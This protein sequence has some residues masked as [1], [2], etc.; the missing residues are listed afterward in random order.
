MIFY[1]FIQFDQNNKLPIYTLFNFNFNKYKLDFNITSDSKYTIFTH[2]WSNNDFD[3][4]KPYIVRSDFTSYFLPIEQKM[5]DYVNNYG[6]LHNNYFSKT[7]NI[8]YI[9]YDTLLIQQFDLNYYNN[10]QIRKLQ[11]F[12]Y[13]T[14]EHLY[15]KYNFDFDKY[16]ND[17][18]I[19]GSN[20]LL[21]TDFILRN[22]QLTNNSDTNTY[23][24]YEPFKKYFILSNKNLLKNYL[25]DYSVTSV[26]NYS[27]HNLNNIDF[28]KSNLNID[29]YLI[30]DQFKQL[31]I[32]FINKNNDYTTIAKQSS[33]SFI[34]K[35]SYSSGFLYD[36][37]D[38]NLYIVSTYHGVVDDID[39]FY[40]W[41]SFQYNDPNNYNNISITAQFRIIGIDIRSDIVIAIYDPNLEFNKEFNVDLSPYKPL[42]INRKHV[43]SDGD[44]VV[45]IGNSY[46]TAI[47]HVVLGKVID[48]IYAGS[49]KE[50]IRNYSYLIQT[51]LSVGMSGSPI[52]Y[53]NNNNELSLIGMI[54]T[55]LTQSPQLCIGV[56]NYILYNILNTLIE[57]YHQNLIIYKDNI[58]LLNN[59]IKDGYNY[60]F[61]GASGNYYNQLH[62]KNKNIYPSL[63][64]LNYAGGYLINNFYLA[65]NIETKQ[66]VISPKDLNK[67]NVIPIYPPLF[68]SKMYSRYLSSNNPI[69]L[70]NY[71]YYDIKTDNYQ[72]YNI[73]RLSTQKPLSTLMQG[74]QPII[75][76]N[77]DSKYKNK[78]LYEYPTVN[79]EYYWYN[80]QTWELENEFI[81]GNIFVEYNDKNGNL[82][83]QNRYEFPYI[84]INYVPYIN[85][86][87][88]LTNNEYNMLL[89][90]KCTDHNNNDTIN[91]CNN[92]T[93]CNTGVNPGGF[94]YCTQ[95]YNYNPN[96]YNPY[97][98]YYACEDII[99]S[100]AKNRCNKYYECER[101]GTDKLTCRQQNNFNYS[102]SIENYVEPT[103]LQ[104]T[105]INWKKKK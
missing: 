32:Y 81:P 43:V 65:F 95:K 26:L 60:S 42:K 73:G 47:Q 100:D 40:I 103:N 104:T 5:I 90:N 10:N 33:C 64:N 27:N 44:D 66:F 28:I 69:L 38:G 62:P 105:P 3:Y 21:F 99:N 68:N 41:A 39:E 11:D 52:L 94:E 82:Y 91:R 89:V 101:T 20:L 48:S 37:E 58:L 55:K 61:F 13:E 6:F 1:N 72:K 50:S 19:Y 76:K 84:L 16:S 83:Y 24:L 87:I 63:A 85:Q 49:E 96:K 30:N 57:N 9:D 70:I 29:D 79:F 67:K 98:Y 23:G 2:F 31:P 54:N 12:Y 46:K 8:N 74:L 7:N 14:N 36:H 88:H 71:S 93:I 35:N 92:Y 25:L 97:Y 22:C 102:N 53:K 34:T 75:K 15:T 56:Q 86:V 77:N 45:L 59:S 51:Y 80:G 78:F 18:N 17:F 4:S